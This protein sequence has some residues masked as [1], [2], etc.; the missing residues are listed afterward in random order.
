MNTWT[1]RF[2]SEGPVASS[3]LWARTPSLRS[4]RRAGHE[5][6]PRHLPRCDSAPRAPRR[7]LWSVA[8]VWTRASGRTRPQGSSSRV[9]TSWR[10]PKLTDAKRKPKTKTTATPASRTTVCRSRRPRHRRR[11]MPR[12][13]FLSVSR[14]EPFRRVCASRNARRGRRTTRGAADVL[15]G[16]SET[17]SPSRPGPGTGAPR[18]HR[19]LPRMLCS[20]APRARARRAFESRVSR[21]K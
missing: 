17:R 20:R 11:S 5:P 16:D 9:P 19:P 1:R 3:G 8:D 2:R 6:I 21:A 18:V 7:H 14:S 13:R 12:P 15:L 4:R 10:F